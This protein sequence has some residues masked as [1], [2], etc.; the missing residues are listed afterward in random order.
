MKAQLLFVYNANSG[1]FS[2]MTDFA[3]KILSPSTYQCQL[4]ALTYGNFTVKRDWK[5]FIERLTIETAFLHKDEFEKQYGLQSALPAVFLSTAST[6]HES[7]TKQ[8][9][10]RCHSLEELKNVVTQK[11]Q[12]HVQH[13]H[14][15]IQ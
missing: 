13:H 2:T 1:L 10:E 3:H 11:I 5:T 12:Q 7:I 8:Q 14:S 4:C 6:L 15:N 9:I